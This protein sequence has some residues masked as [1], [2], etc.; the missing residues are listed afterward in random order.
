[1]IYLRF[2]ITLNIIKISTFQEFM[3]QRIYGFIISVLIFSDILKYIY[4]ITG[5]PFYALIYLY[6]IMYIINVTYTIYYY[7]NKD[8]KSKNYNYNSKII[9]FLQILEKT[10][11][12]KII[13]DYIDKLMIIEILK[14][15][16][17]RVQATIIGN[18]IKKH[19]NEKTLMNLD[20]E[21]IPEQ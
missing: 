12:Y 9:Q 13:K 11:I 20:I 16:E 5:G 15:Y 8:K 18:Y 3:F 7:F 19:I 6:L 10:L 21:K 17:Y 1:M 4:V 2:Y 14:I